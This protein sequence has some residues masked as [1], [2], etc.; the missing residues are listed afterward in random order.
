MEPWWW[1]STL[2]VVLP[3]Y[4]ALRRRRNIWAILAACLLG[5]ALGA[6]LEGVF[7]ATDKLIAGEN[8]IFADAI[9]KAVEFPKNFFV[10]LLFIVAGALNPE[11]LSL[12]VPRVVEDILSDS[13]LRRFEVS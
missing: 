4:L 13:T 3:V 9:V 12:L 5:L 10:G 1:V 8:F 2:T 6:V 7:F 11:L